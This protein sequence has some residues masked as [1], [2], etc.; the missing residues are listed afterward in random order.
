MHLAIAAR[1]QQRKK[2]THR[3][4]YDYIACCQGQLGEKGEVIISSL[5]TQNPTLN[6]QNFYIMYITL[7]VIALSLAMKRR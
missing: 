2:L 5:N 3:I 7:F 4:E 6:T 1:P